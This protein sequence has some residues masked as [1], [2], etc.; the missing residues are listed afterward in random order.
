MVPVLESHVCDCV[1]TET[2]AERESS[3]VALLTSSF[4]RHPGTFTWKNKQ[5]HLD[6]WPIRP[7]A[8]RS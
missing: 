6:C 4:F 3:I 1:K 7:H 5:S 8:L 2:E